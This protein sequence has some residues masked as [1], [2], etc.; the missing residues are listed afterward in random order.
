[1]GIAGI[2][3]GA[4]REGEN[5]SEG[6]ALDGRSGGGQ[7]LQQESPQVGQKTTCIWEEIC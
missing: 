1:M 3:D 2:L 4:K 7:T 6:G 5:C